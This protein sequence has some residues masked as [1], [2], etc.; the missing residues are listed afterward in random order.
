MR[1][2]PEPFTDWSL[3]NESTFLSLLFCVLSGLD[4]VDDK[5]IDF[6]T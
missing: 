2:D 3:F 5:F 1:V 6:E 4:D